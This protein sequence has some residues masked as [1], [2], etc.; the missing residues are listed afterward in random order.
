M[1]RER[2]I[3][4]LEAL[5]TGERFEKVPWEVQWVNGSGISTIKQYAE[6]VETACQL[7]EKAVNEVLPEISFPTGEVIGDWSPENVSKE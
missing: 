3:L 1:N 6:P 5:K 7:V 4:V 2:M